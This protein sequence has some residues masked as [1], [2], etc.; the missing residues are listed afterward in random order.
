MNETTTYIILP[1]DDFT[2]ELTAL[3]LIEFSGG[4]EVG[5]TV[6]FVFLGD[7]PDISKE[8]IDNIV[9]YRH[10]YHTLHDKGRLL[11]RQKVAQPMYLNASFDGDDAAQ[12]FESKPLQISARMSKFDF[13]SVSND[14]TIVVVSRTNSP[15]LALYPIVKS[16]LKQAKLTPR[17]FHICCSENDIANDMRQFLLDNYVNHSDTV[18]T[19]IRDDAYRTHFTMLQTADAVLNAATSAPGIVGGQPE[20]MLYTPASLDHQQ[21]AEALYRLSLLHFFVKEMTESDGALA[22]WQ[23]RT[24]ADGSKLWRE[25]TCFPA[26][27][28]M[29]SLSEKYITKYSDE[30]NAVCSDS[31]ISEFVDKMNAFKVKIKGMTEAEKR[32]ARIRS[33]F[34]AVEDKSP[35]AWEKKPEHKPYKRSGIFPDSIFDSKSHLS[36]PSPIL[37]W[38]I[39]DAA[40]APS[41]LSSAVA[42]QIRH[43][44]IGYWYIF[45]KCL[46]NANILESTTKLFDIT[47]IDL[48]SS[49]VRNNTS[50]ALGNVGKRLLDG[51]FL[52]AIRRKEQREVYAVTSPLTGFA[53]TVGMLQKENVH[54][55]NFA[56]ADSDFK[57]FVYNYV[58]CI[59]DFSDNF[60]KFI[61]QNISDEAKQKAESRG[62]NLLDMYPYLRTHVGLLPEAK[63]KE[64]NIFG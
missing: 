36:S 2:G 58:R 28:T 4:F 45:Y 11:F 61:A 56:E 3:M 12:L 16:R 34:N 20:G 60:T 32:L 26:L 63:D 39:C 48:D 55:V 22:K 41:A 37:A 25:G 53:L 21:S 59:G 10:S 47:E 62:H 42:E 50:I 49:S 30:F 46:F 38:E 54:P 15:S 29:L 14:D 43:Q 51:R 27:H 24:E 13:S 17:L 8:H 40:F 33:L 23:T 1:A 5:G 31:E 7:V 18:I 64:N 57:E 9:S 35:H 6:Q 44:C 52:F 19:G